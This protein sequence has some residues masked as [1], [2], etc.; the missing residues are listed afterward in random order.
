MRD[1]IVVGSGPAGT[2]AALGLAGKDVLVLDVGRVDSG[3]QT[4][5][6]NLY[7]LRQTKPDLFSELIGKNFESLYNLRGENLSLKLK[8]P[9]TSFIVRGWKELSPVVSTNFNVTMSFA[10][11]GLANAWGAGAY[12]YDHHDLRNFP[13]SALE[14]EPF[15]KN[16]TRR[17][18]VAGTADDLQQFFGSMDDVLEPLRLSEPASQIL[19]LYNRHKEW[20][21]NQSIY[22]GRTRLAV[23]TRNF[24]NRNPYQYDNLEFFKPYNPAIYNPV[25]T[26]REMIREG[27]IDYRSELL[28]TSFREITDGVVVEVRNLRTGSAEQFK[29]RK[30]FLGAGAINTAKI[31]LQSANDYQ[32]RLPL[33][34]NPISCLPILS[35]RRIGSALDP[36]DGSL[37]QLN[38]VYEQPG[39][40]ERIQATLYGTTGPLRT[41]VLFDLPISLDASL[42]WS[43]YLLPAVSLV[44][45]FFPASEGQNKSLQLTESGALNIDG[46]ITVDYVPVEEMLVRA[47][48]HLGFLCHRAL[49]YRPQIGSGLHYAGTLPMKECPALYQTDRDGRLSGTRNIFVV[50]AACFPWLPAKNHTL[51]IMANALRIGTRQRMD[52]Q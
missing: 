21:H 48:R 46:E 25:F 40:G 14:L 12:R 4:L 37:G 33:L 45:I 28:V 34:D 31:V 39:T 3:E 29:C 15:Y 44:M 43:R 7:E 10:Q 19:D 41:D 24:R 22:I 51:T 5:D 52:L 2:F 6:T 50:D 1:A 18:G 8:A 36:L 20:F 30:L 16:V 27:S 9:R 42:I 38:L 35:P 11:G 26:L 13:I 32:T 17:I 47:F 49:C 23:L